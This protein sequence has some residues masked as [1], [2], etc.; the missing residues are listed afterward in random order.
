[1]KIRLFIAD[2]HELVRDG[3]RSLID[4]NE[5]MEIV[6]EAKD[7]YETVERVKDLTPDIVIMD[8]GMPNLNGIEATRKIMSRQSGIRVIALS[9]H[10]GKE[11]VT[12]ALKAG[13]SA[14]LLK[15]CAF[16]ELEKAIRTV[17][18][19]NTYLGLEITDVVVQDL[20][21]GGINETS[22]YDILTNREREVLQLLAEGK[23]TKEIAYMLNRSVK[24]IDT[25]RYNII[26]KLGLDSFADLIKYAVKQG[27][28]TLDN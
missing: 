2:D 1:M 28:T 22:A 12:E 7:G 16:E 14:Y 4:R 6:G 18:N 27:I 21:Q 9:M 23:S 20:V 26:K 5:D 13:V 25:H 8:I 19:G 11:F 17:Y 15:D 24:T 10:N 3:I